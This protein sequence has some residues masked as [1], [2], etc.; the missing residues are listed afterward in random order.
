YFF[1]LLGLMGD[2]W[3]DGFLKDI[4]QIGP[5]PTDAELH[6]LASLSGAVMSEI[7]ERREVG[8]RSFD[9]LT[10]TPDFADR[11]ADYARREPS[12]SGDP[13][14]RTRM[15]VIKAMGNVPHPD[16]VRVLGEFLTDYTGSMTTLEPEAGYIGANC[17]FAVRSLSQLI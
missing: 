16:I 8:R 12:P 11:L 10:S 2:D 7:P 14:V 13:T 5:N 17:H 4:S 15:W 1:T 3:S 6:M 9:L